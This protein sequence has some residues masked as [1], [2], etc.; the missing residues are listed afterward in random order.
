MTHQLEPLI[1]Q[2]RQH[3]V[4]V[5]LKRLSQLLV[6]DELADQE[7]HTLMRHP[8]DLRTATDPL[9]HCASATLLPAAGNLST[10]AATV[11]LSSCSYCCSSSETAATPWPRHNRSLVLGSNTS[12]ITVPWVY[13]VT[14]GPLCS[15]Q[16]PPQPRPQ[17][18][19]QPLHQCGCH[20]YP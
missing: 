16:S 12:T 8:S 17:R 15:P 18:R 11:F 14:V 3:R 9:P 7:L 4:R 2:P 1:P 13:W 5:L 10:I 6:R 19:P 20:A